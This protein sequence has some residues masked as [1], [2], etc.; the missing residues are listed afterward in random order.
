MALLEVDD[1][2]VR[3]GGLTALDG[4]R[5]AVQPGQVTGLIGPNGAGKTTLFNVVTGLQRAD[6][7]TIRFCDADITS[8]K[9]HRRARLGIARTFQ[10]LEAFGSL[11]VRENVLVA[12]EARAGRS[13]QRRA[14]ASTDE[15]LERVGLASVADERVDALPTGTGRL[16]ELA[17]ALAAEPRLLLLDEPSSGLNQQETE[18]MSSVLL[19]LVRDGGIG[20]LLVEH[21]MPFVMSTCALIHVL[22]FGRVIASGPPSTVQQDASVIAA[23]LGGDAATE[24][25]V[26]VVALQAPAPVPAADIAPAIELRDVHAGYGEIQVLHGIDLEVRAGEVVA[27]LGANGAGKSTVLKVLSGQIVPGSGEYLLSGSIANG[28]RSDVL[29]RAGVCTIPEGRGIF[30]N[31]TVLE[32]LRMA[33][34]AGV[35]LPTVLDRAFV[36]FPRLAERRTQM[37][38]TLSG[39][40]Q[41]MLALAR[42]LTTNPRILLLDELSMGLAPLV[43]EELYEVV[44]GVSSTGVTTIVV[45]Q[46][47]HDILHIAHR[48]VVMVHGQV[49]DVGR[50]SDI[51]TEL[52]A[53]YLGHEQA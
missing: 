34:H 24:A 5:I 53:V 26:P 35:D 33:T 45:E 28:A 27:L 21:D 19:D 49:A 47:A 52:A 8:A 22:D 38:G 7:G 15:L 48:A 41:Q 20:V 36:Q 6:R 42:A 32:N 3:F 43:V 18:A 46:F 13:Q 29:A 40:E 12:A 4:V 37:A 17:R 50:P 51:A 31:L 11:S 30:R 10:R 23:Y 9:P 14:A 16:V 44:A 2:S 1:V 25:N 39:G